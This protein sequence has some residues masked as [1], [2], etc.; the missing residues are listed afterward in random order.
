[1]MP[2]T[3]VLTTTVQP[4]H[5]TQPAR[6]QGQFTGNAHSRLLHTTPG[7]LLTIPGVHCKGKRDLVD[8]SGVLKVG[9]VKLYTHTGIYKTYHLGESLHTHLQT[10]YDIHCQ[11]LHVHKL[12]LFIACYVT[13]G[14]APRQHVH[15]LMLFIACF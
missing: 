5:W 1:M 8:T 14:V 6:L 13:N 10:T 4:D 11:S 12:M 3:A 2:T 7:T 9:G 15:R